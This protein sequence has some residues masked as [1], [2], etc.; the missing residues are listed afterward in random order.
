MTD[1][2]E[3]HLDCPQCGHSDCMTR[4]ENGST[5]CHSCG[6]KG[7]DGVKK[8]EVVKTVTPKSVT[9]KYE[10]H[11][12]ISDRVNKYYDIKNGV[13]E[14]GNTIYRAYKYPTQTKYRYLPKDFSHNRGF[15]LTELFGRDKFN[16]GSSKYITIVEG[17]EDAPSAYQMLGEKS[18]VVALP[19]AT[20]TKELLKNEHEFLNSY[21]QIIVCLDNDDAG[22]AA[23][24][25]LAEAFPNKIYTVSLTTYK[26]ANEY[27]MAG[28]G[29]DF[30]YAWIN[31]V[32][33]V[34][35]FDISTP[36]RFMELFDS[37]ED[38]EYVPTGISNFDE[39]ML[40]LFQGH[41][42]VFQ[43]PE[44]VGKTELFRF[45]EYHLIT[46][47]PDI[48]FA[49]CHLEETQLRSLLGL[50]SYYHKKNMTRKQLISDPT[51]VKDAI[52]DMMKTEDVHLF[53]IGV[54]EDPMVL[55]DRI[56]YYAN[57]C[58]C[59]YVFI[60]PLQ[61]LAY[62]RTTNETIEQFLTRLSILLSRTASE[63]GCGIITI[64]HEN[65][66]GSIRDCRMIG[67]RASVV[68]KLKR[69]VESTDEEERN[70]T[71]MQCVKN[72]PASFTG[73]AGELTFDVETFMI[74]E[75]L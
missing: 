15:K 34:P 17:E 30:M 45:F 49:T 29:A 53:S 52:D 70:T 33:F 1:K 35:P 23:T 54:D 18:P 20:I 21:S 44:G 9:E 57:V 37:S 68:V 38:A 74:K 75:K 55:V 59:K 69:D 19:S 67:K 62:Q 58:G 16:A 2:F 39:N 72:R 51:E 56:K 3:A 42:T 11:R 6:K 60:E 13:D 36:D 64:A 71:V 43:A 22:K 8:T 7:F 32:K 28:K 24:L 73:Y 25:K 40:G 46:N 12:S 26:D 66:E 48:P 31:R 50:V 4:W 5:Y 41:F 47:H 27:L 63:T 14:H 61:D 65:D 10:N